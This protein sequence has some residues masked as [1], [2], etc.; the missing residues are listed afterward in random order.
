MVDKA[1]NAGMGDLGLAMQVAL[2]GVSTGPAIEDIS[3]EED[4]SDVE[5]EGCM[6]DLNTQRRLHRQKAY[7]ETALV[8]VP[9]PLSGSP[10]SES[11]HVIRSLAST[12]SPTF[13]PP[14]SSD[15]FVAHHHHHR[16]AIVK[17]SQPP[18]TT[19]GSRGLITP[20]VMSTVTVGN[21]VKSTK[22]TRK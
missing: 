18:V 10:E 13:S 21:P 12:I 22:S 19:R 4:I 5:W 16:P 17:K 6:R 14:S 20:T 7:K 2:L 15:H 11:Q 8:V 1:H 3:S 9:S